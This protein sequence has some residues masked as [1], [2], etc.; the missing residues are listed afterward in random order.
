MNYNE[1]KN[2]KDLVKFK[3]ENFDK[4]ILLKNDDKMLLLFALKEKQFIETHSSTTDAI[5]YILEGEVKFDFYDEN[6]KDRIL[7][8][9]E[10]LKFEKNQR[11]SVIANKDSKF[12]VIRI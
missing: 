11:H 8:T 10:G 3:N 4:N 6:K 9:G 5:I 7:K 12:I 1:P 2:L